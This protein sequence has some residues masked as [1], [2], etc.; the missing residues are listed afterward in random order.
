VKTTV[1]ISDALLERA[2]AH[3]RATRRTLRAVIEEGLRRVLRD[4]RPSTSYALPDH[5]VGNADD[6]DPLATRSWSELAE[7]IYGGR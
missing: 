5:S 2:R 6:P 1:D 7:E 3:A 4:E